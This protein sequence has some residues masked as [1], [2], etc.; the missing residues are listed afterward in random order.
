[1]VRL[2]QIWVILGRTAGWRWLSVREIPS[3]VIK[4]GHD[5]IKNQFQ[6]LH[7]PPTQ[8]SLHCSGTLFHPS[9]ALATVQ[10]K[11]FR[12][13]ENLFSCSSSTVCLRSCRVKL[14]FR[15]KLESPRGL[16]EFLRIRYETLRHL[17][18]SSDREAWY[19]FVDLSTPSDRRTAPPPHTWF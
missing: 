5:R 9:L 11:V 13:D 6:S 17:T 19:H 8:R 4:L 1:M 10:V 16:E 2:E 12:I 3:K 14:R 7:T 18:L 15:I